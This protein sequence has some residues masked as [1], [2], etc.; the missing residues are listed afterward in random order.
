MLYGR[1]CPLVLRLVCLCGCCLSLTGCGNK[2]ARVVK[3]EEPSADPHPQIRINHSDPVL[4]KISRE[5]LE[6]VRA[7]LSPQEVRE[8][9]GPAFFEA[10]AG[11]ALT[12][13]WTDTDRKQH[14]HVVFD[15]GKVTQLNAA[16]LDF[17]PEKVVRANVDRIRTGITEKEVLAI[18]GPSGS[19][20]VNGPGKT[21]LWERDG[22]TV[23]IQLENGQVISKIA[24]GIN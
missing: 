22:K 2:Q 7:G 10:D 6:R 24:D 17:Q 13:Q 5:Q 18:L 4:P 23:L 9:L 20:L 11:N 21:L 8:I 12:M 19:I 1:R 3:L 15:H 16:G 14:I